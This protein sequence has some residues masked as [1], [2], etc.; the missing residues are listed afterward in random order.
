M[1]ARPLIN[2]A[3]RS[4]LIKMT[5]ATLSQYFANPR[6]EMIKQHCRGRKVLDIGLGMGTLA[7][8]M[9]RDGYFVTGLDVDNTSLYEDIQP[10]I[11]DGLKMPFRNHSFDTATLVCVLHHCVNQSMVLRE[12]MR[13]ADRVVVVE[14]TYRNGFE[15]KLV[16]FRDCIENWEFYEHGYRTYEEW[17]KL[18]KQN[19]WKT[20]LV[21][22]WSSWDFGFLYGRQI[23]FVIDK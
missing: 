6:W 20:K 19:G 14:D 21:R 3:K 15:R 9:M 2:F 12:A 22:S 5:I 17:E 8:N 1:P 13:V 4:N 23:L 10:T 11:Y 16:G 18:C 7:K